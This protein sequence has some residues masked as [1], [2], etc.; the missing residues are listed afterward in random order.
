MYSF[1]VTTAS[2]SSRGYS[3]SVAPVLEYQE[4]PFPTLFFVLG[5]WRWCSV[6]W[7]RC[8]H[9]RSWRLVRTR[10]ST[11]THIQSLPLH[12]LTHSNA[13][14]HKH[15]HT[16]TH[17]Q[18][19]LSTMGTQSNDSATRAQRT[20]ACSLLSC[21]VAASLRPRAM[22]GRVRPCTEDSPAD[23][24]ATLLQHLRANIR[25]GPSFVMGPTRAGRLAS[26]LGVT[27]RGRNVT[28]DA[29]AG[30]ARRWQ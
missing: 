10:P 12:S 23:A 8:T 30:A 20:R 6:Q 27:L 21:I 22:Q 1:T 29:A 24:V 13:R 15:A 14:T 2:N 26:L 25:G 16:C 4:V 5:T 18:A 7:I 28:P 17:T 9:T 19:C 3:W 11:H